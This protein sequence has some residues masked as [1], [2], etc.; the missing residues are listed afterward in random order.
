VLSN[1]LHSTLGHS[2]WTSYPTEKGEELVYNPIL[3]FVTRA[4]KARNKSDD[5]VA[6]PVQYYKQDALVKAKQLIRP[7]AGM[8]TRASA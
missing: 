5:V 8:S 1:E 7:L 3:N 4:V 6:K 2:G